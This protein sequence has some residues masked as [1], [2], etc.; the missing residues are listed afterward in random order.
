MTNEISEPSDLFDANGVLIQ[1]GWARKPILRYNR[2]KIRAK[3]HRLKEWDNYVINH[4]DYNF[5]VTIADVGYMGLVT[6]ELNDYKEQ[7]VYNGGLQKFF[8]K[9]TWKLPLSSEQGDIEFHH[10]TFDLYIKKLPDRREI[11]FDYPTFA[12]KGLKGKITLY[13][14]PG[15]D[16]LVPETKPSFQGIYIHVSASEG[17]AF[18]PTAITPGLVLASGLNPNP[19][20]GLYSQL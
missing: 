14:D 5:G 4:P 3:W 2:D 15:K 19:E 13:Q 7:K 10:E 12:E 11:S 16:S 6:F 17:E 18:A 8:T 9:G 1:D 20:R